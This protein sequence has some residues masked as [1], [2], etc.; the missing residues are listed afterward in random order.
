M[1]GW[2]WTVALAMGSGLTFFMMETARKR[3]LHK[4]IGHG[5]AFYKRGAN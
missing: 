4:E 2:W 5:K 3:V 1:R